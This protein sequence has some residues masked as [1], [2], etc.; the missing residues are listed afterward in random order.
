[1]P[2]LAIVS[3]PPG[4]VPLFEV[5]Y[6]QALSGKHN[7]IEQLV[8]NSS[9]DMLEETVRVHRPVVQVVAHF[10]ASKF[11]ARKAEG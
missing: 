1:M 6:P 5:T 9:L 7:I 11:K 3:P 4:D 8:L 10:I 2:T